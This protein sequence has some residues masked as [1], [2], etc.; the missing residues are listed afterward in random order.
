MK[1]ELVSRRKRR[2]D[3]HQTEVQGSEEELHRQRHWAQL[4]SDWIDSDLP[5]GA[6][7]L[8]EE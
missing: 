3:S 4:T 7:V 2:A 6:K 5:W 8:D 1:I